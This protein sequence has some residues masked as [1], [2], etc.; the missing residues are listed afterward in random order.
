ML[1]IA[2]ML[3][4]LATAVL[5]AACATMQADPTRSAQRT[6]VPLKVRARIQPRTPQRF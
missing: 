1:A 2:V 3:L 4:P 5:L 6:A